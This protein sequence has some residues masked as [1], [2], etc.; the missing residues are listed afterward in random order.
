MAGR[1][2]PQKSG[3]V[4]LVSIKAEGLNGSGTIHLIPMPE[5]TDPARI[6]GRSSRPPLLIKS[7][8]FGII[9][10]EADRVWWPLRSSKPWGGGYA[11]S[12]RFDSYPFRFLLVFWGNPI[13]FSQLLIIALEISFYE[14]A[15]CLGRK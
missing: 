14:T 10:P 12:G 13:Y 8:P 11:V 5:T 1:R 2:L 6:M 9:L 7:F 4:R 3:R 15:L